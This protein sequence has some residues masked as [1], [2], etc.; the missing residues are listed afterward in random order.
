[1]SGGKGVKEVVTVHIGQAGCQVG[2]TVWE[3]FCK[4][5]DIL[6]DGTRA[7]LDTEDDTYCSF[8]CET[9]RG[10]HVPRSV[11]CD[12]D[13]SSRDDI[14][15][16]DY[17]KL[18]HPENVLS[19]KQDCRSN[20]FDGR[21]AAKI[22][23]IKDNIMDRIRLNVELCSNLQG[24]FVFH[25]F[26]GGTGTGIGCEVLDEITDVYKGKCLFQPL[27]YPSYQFSSSIVEPYNCVL[28]THYSRESVDMSLMLDNQ[29]AYR[30]CQKNLGISNPDFNHINRLL[31][32]VISTCTTSLR[33]ESELNAS[34]EEIRT[35][36]IPTPQ[37][38]YPILSL[39]P[40][41]APDKGH[42]ESFSTKEIV[43]DI[44]E[45]KCSL[46]DCQYLMQN[47][48]LA[49]VICLRGKEPLNSE[50]LPEDKKDGS[51][52]GSNMGA[53]RGSGGFAQTLKPGKT[54]APIQVNTVISSLS[55]LMKGRR[56]LV[57]F[58]PWVAGGAFKVGVVGEP[59]VCP[60]D[61]FMAPSNRQGAAMS[62][63][64]AV[65]QLFVRQYT[66]FL[67]LFFHKAYIW[68]MIDAGGEMECFTEAKEG[69]RSII[70]GY[71]H[72]M[73][74]CRLAEDE[75]PGRCSMIGATSHTL[76]PAQARR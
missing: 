6:P 50:D 11:F 21:M 65:R 49:A 39:A 38:R 16:S 68:Q 62:N 8:F 17:K 24:F 52:A 33:F 41:R 13:P 34:L 67:K 22:Y 48:Y 28:A 37:Y 40:V 73:D 61:N 71:E 25:S 3:L 64:T 19:Y 54:M 4:E 53:S 74:Q 42:F 18:F 9:A 7:D 72:L 60:A 5:H 55:E 69:M 15:S 1:M 36:L 23:K 57:K 35:N 26:G 56:A 45:E 46:A 70:D 12:T 76:D 59:P 20:F 75:P 2:L 43:K 51:M 58:L 44:F 30:M 63:T 14:N 27:V 47:R 32:Q 10:Q 66:K 29:A 31:A